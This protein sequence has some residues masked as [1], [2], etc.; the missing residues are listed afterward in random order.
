MKPTILALAFL[1]TLAACGAD[2]GEPA[3]GKATGGEAKALE[4]AAAMLD[5][6]RS[7]S[8]PPQPAAPAVP[9]KE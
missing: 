9:A 2:E 4:D 5:E 8:P 6:R 3:P 7:T 1:L